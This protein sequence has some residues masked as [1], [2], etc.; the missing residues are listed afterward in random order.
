MV[1]DLPKTF[2]A[3]VALSAFVAWSAFV[4]LVALSA[5]V[6]VV[7]VAAWS[8]F[9][10]LVALSAFVAV[11]AVVALSA[12]V[13]LVALS[14]FVAVFAVVAGPA[15]V[16]VPL[17]LPAIFPVTVS[18]ATTSTTLVLP[19]LS[20][21]PFRVPTSAS[22]TATVL[23]WASLAPET[24]LTPPRLPTARFKPPTNFT[25]L[26]LMIHSHGHAISTE[27]PGVK[28]AFDPENMRIQI[29]GTLGSRVNELQ[30][31]MAKIQHDLK[32]HLY[33]RPSL[34][35][36]E[37]VALVTRADPVTTAKSA[38]EYTRAFGPPSPSR[39][40]PAQGFAPPIVKTEGISPPA[41]WSIFFGSPSAPSVHTRPSARPVDTAGPTVP[42]IV[43]RLHGAHLTVAEAPPGAVPGLAQDLR[44]CA[45]LDPRFCRQNSPYF[46]AYAFIKAKVGTIVLKIRP[47]G[48]VRGFAGDEVC[49]IL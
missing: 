46:D 32:G 24:V 23:L 42:P 20:V 29:E 37:Q 27:I 39:H 49:P 6:A 13:A 10:A 21:V 47:K 15:F 43:V 30:T 7:A 17:R 16:A 8:A 38:P 9:L 26:V 12:F 4:A 25:A 28:L 36:E 40:M 33:S 3:L 35:Q 22:V 11:V 41:P 48:L 5:F 14:A 18:P 34:H 19:Y 44:N 1:A 31:Q 2:V 45:S